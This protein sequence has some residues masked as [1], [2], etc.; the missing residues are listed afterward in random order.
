MSEGNHI[1]IAVITAA[2]I[3]IILLI[4]YKIERLEEKVKALTEQ[5]QQ[6]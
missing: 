2:A 5:I 1:L 4:D 3:L 6:Q